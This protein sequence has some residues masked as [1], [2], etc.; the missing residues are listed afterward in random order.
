MLSAMSLGDW[1]RRLFSPSPA[2]NAAGAED[3]AA[4]REEYGEEA[5]QQPA[6]GGVVGGVSG[7][8]GLEDAEAAEDAVEADESPRDPAP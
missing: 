2:P 1:F 8:A 7:L 4:L 3:E 6:P 5:L